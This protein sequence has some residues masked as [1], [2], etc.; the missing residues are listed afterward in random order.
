MSYVGLMCSILYSEIIL[1]IFLPLLFMFLWEILINIMGEIINEIHKYSP[2][3]NGKGVSLL[4]AFKRFNTVYHCQ[5]IV[6]YVLKTFC[7]TL[8]LK[9]LK[10]HYF[11]SVLPIL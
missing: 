2:L 7:S 8:I 6:H 11:Y 1:N 5:Q 9:V 10:K 3:N 4:M